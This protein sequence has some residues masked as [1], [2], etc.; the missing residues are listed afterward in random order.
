MADP[1]SDDDHHRPAAREGQ[2]LVPRRLADFLGDWSL[3]REIVH[4]DGTRAR[5][6]GRACWRTEGAGALQEETGVLE[7]AGQGFAAQRRYLWAEDLDVRF[8]DGRFFH[9]VP[10][11]GGPVSHLCPPDHYAGVYQF[12]GWPDWE[13]RW[14]VSG[15]RKAYVMVSRYTPL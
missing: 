5:F 8:E 7:M 12:A 11:L 1:V 13:V 6:V 2:S 15:P 10:P 4:D 3:S 9:R 14:R